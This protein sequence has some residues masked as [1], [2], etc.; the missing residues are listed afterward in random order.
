MGTRY[1]EVVRGA[2]IAGDVAS[3]VEV[4]LLA[5]PQLANPAILCASLLFWQLRVA[6]A[7]QL[8]AI[9]GAAGLIWLAMPRLWNSG[10][11]LV[12]TLGVSALFL[13]GIGALPQLIGQYL[14]K[15]AVEKARV[16]AP[17]GL[18]CNAPGTLKMLDAAPPGVIFAHI[19]LGPKIIVQTHHDATS[20]PYHR[21]WREIG[22]MM[23]TWQS[24]PEAARAAISERADYLLICDDARFSRRTVQ[25]RRL[26]NSLK[27]EVPDW[28]EPVEMP[29][30]APFRLYRVRG[31]GNSR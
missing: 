18:S 20:G 21:G 12:R 4:R 31:A 7:A 9:T 13:V 11:V 17:R 6:P 3:G 26:A 22:V 24:E 23:R 8:F 14:P 15:N 25:Q 1:L 10:N 16:N 29:E 2:S 30:R 28:L 5:G 27:Q 19:D